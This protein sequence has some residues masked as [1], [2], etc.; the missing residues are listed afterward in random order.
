VNGELN[1]APRP[2]RPD[3]RLRLYR[4]LGECSAA[5][6]LAVTMHLGDFGHALTNTMRGADPA[7]YFHVVDGPD[8]EPLALIQLFRGGMFDTIVHPAHRGG[9]FERGL[10][11]W[12]AQAEQALMAQLGINIERVIIDG[13]TG[14]PVRTALLR[15]LGFTAADSPYMAITTRDL[16]DNPIPAPVL[17][18]GFTIRPA[19]GL[20]E[21]DAIGAVHASA[22]KR[23][24]WTPGLYR[25]VMET[26][27]F[28]AERE[29]LVVA[30]D[31]E[32]AAFLVYWLDPVSKSGLFEP[33]GCAEH[34]QRRG[35]VKALM[36]H[37][38]GI[39]R[40]AGMHTAIVKHETDNPASTA[41]YASIGFTR[42]HEYFE[43]ARP[44]PAVVE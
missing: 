37:T 26:P 3:D 19:A 15:E 39:M 41:A 8:G 5:A 34:F 14:E 12:S 44:L 38:L 17:P 23:A 32:L 2:Y 31:G 42:K 36:S 9:D 28:D 43:Y 4:F 21:A 10:L 18:D 25:K 24:N 6:D 7:L 30:P 16:I 35:L 11:E 1:P 20:H 29:M 13:L 40:D 22:F 27:G 33:V